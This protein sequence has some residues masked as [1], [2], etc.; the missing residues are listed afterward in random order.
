VIFLEGGREMYGPKA[1]ELTGEFYRAMYERNYF[2]S[3]ANVTTASN[4]HGST[5]GVDAQ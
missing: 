4:A 2:A 1:A 3:K 5:Q